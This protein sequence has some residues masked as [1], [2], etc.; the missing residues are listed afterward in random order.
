MRLREVKDE[1]LF[2]QK[3]RLGRG[4]LEGRVE[5]L[6]GCPIGDDKHLNM[7]KLGYQVPRLIAQAHVRSGLFIRSFHALEFTTHRTVCAQIM[8]LIATDAQWQALTP[9]LI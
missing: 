6:R 2:L 1:A 8:S 3:K 5:A 9:R 4:K 7:M